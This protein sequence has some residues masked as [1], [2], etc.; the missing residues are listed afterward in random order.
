MSVL[1]SNPSEMEQINAL[2]TR[3]AELER[4][5]QQCRCNLGQELAAKQQTEVRL[6][7]ILNS[8]IA[9]IISF[10]VLDDLSWKY[11]YFSAG[12]ETV[13]GFTSE[14][15]T[16]DEH[17][18]C[19]RVHPDDYSVAITQSLASIQK[20]EQSQKEYRFFHKDGSLRWI[21]SVLA[22]R[23]DEAAKCWVVTAVDTDITDR[24]RTENALRE[25][26]ERFRQIAANVQEAFFVESADASEILYISPAYERI[27]GRSPE[28]L[29][30]N[31]QAWMDAVLPEDREQLKNVLP[32]KLKGQSNQDEFRIL[33]PDGRIR[34]IYGRTTP[35]FDDSGQLVCHVGMAEDI[36]LRK[37]V[38]LRWRQQTRREQAFSHV[39]QSIRKSLSLES[40]FS[41]AIAE[42]A[43]LLKVEQV[44]LVQYLPERRC[45]VHLAEYI[46]NSHLE[47]TIG[48]EIPDEGNPFA[49]QLKQLQVVRVDTNHAINDPINLEV[50]KS[51]P[52]AWLLTPIAT[53]EGIWGSLTLHKADQTVPWQ[54]EE[55]ELAWRVADQ[56][57]IAIQQAAL[58]EQAQIELEERQRAEAALQKLNQ[59]LELRVQART[60]E[61]QASQEV[62]RQREQDFRTLV[63]NAPDIIVRLDSNLYCLYAN[64]ATEAITDIS[65]NALVGK[66]WHEIGQ[67]MGLVALWEKVMQKALTTQTEQTVEF[68]IPAATGM[69][70]FQSRFVPEFAPNGSPESTLVIARDITSLK[71][72][73][74]ALRQSEEL[75]RRL[76]EESPIGIALNFAYNTQLTKVNRRFCEMLGYQPEDLMALTDK[77]LTHPA[78]W[79]I[80]QPLLAQLVAGE[81]STYQLE[82]RYIQKHGELLWV[83][84]TTT[85]VRDHKGTL[86][87][88]LA[89]AED[90][91]QRKRIEA[92]HQQAEIALRQSE[93]QFR[94]LFQDAPIAIAL[95][96]PQTYRFL[97]ANAM[98]STMIGYS[99]AELLQMTF[100]DITYG[101]DIAKDIELA[102]SVSNGEISHFQMEKRLVSKSGEIKWANLTTTLIR[103][104]GGTPLYSMGMI[105]DISERK[106]AEEQLKASLQEKEVLLKEIH[107][108]VKNNLQIISSLLRM[109]SRHA[110]DTHTGELFKEAQD[111]V[112]SMAFIHEQLYQSPDLSSIDFGDYLQ[113][114]VNNLFRSYGINHKQIALSIETQGINLTL[115]S[116]IPC[117]LIV[118]ELV[119]NSLKYAFPDCQQGAISIHL[120]TQF[121]PE[122][123]VNTQAVL[124][125]TDDGVGIP[126]AMVWQNTNSLGLRIVRNLV[127]Q[128][129]GNISLD[130]QYGT[131]FTITFPIELQ[132]D[133]SRMHSNVPVD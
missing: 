92:E 103:D 78:D 122:V 47:P 71:R 7:D 43:Q 81:I 9:A 4:E 49:E 40:I 37:E 97:H 18:W 116:A 76:F 124:K 129:K 56:L 84:F 133:A 25:S 86:L 61:L 105:E 36:T 100:V 85:A 120:H 64:P 41:T 93:E 73:E 90:I 29:Y 17:L 20:C 123:M 28:P 60:Q 55:V 95:V 99:T 58:Y 67:T 102:K 74:V 83:Q 14:E 79:L 125:I 104:Q 19:S 113:T 31:P 94:R 27:W 10:R 15:L 21:S 39:V 117:G 128:L 8:A 30:Q 42:I 12:C 34:W 82:K 11:D 87:F 48:F 23:Y 91:S 22:T 70:Y 75:F 50:A 130:R 66:P 106:Q 121:N 96:H 1:P 127:A 101:A 77:A 88:S 62:L 2:Q 112:Q 63:D 98:Y 108:R 109:Q 16:L 65:H 72:A 46:H 51:F 115:N 32:A 35:V 13:F 53:N 119:S 80:E 6:N 45:W 54:D 57:A 5:L 26:E 131:S 114:L 33:R 126:Q 111:R 68:V 24:K 69:R 118:N 38:E 107:H 52:T 132:P 59:E 44:V 110:R 89:M 3:V